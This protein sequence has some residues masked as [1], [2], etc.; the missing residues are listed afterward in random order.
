MEAIKFSE[1][2]TGDRMPL[3]D[4]DGVP[5]I[6]NQ[7]NRLL[8]WGRLKK[9]LAAQ[10]HTD[11]VKPDDTKVPTGA[12]V[13]KRIKATEDDLQTKLEP[14]ETKLDEHDTA[15][16]NAR[17]I[18]NEA[19]TAADSAYGMATTAAT[20]AEDAVSA[21]ATAQN[22]ADN[23]ALAASQAQTAANSAKAD[24]ERFE[25]ELDGKISAIS[26]AQ[27]QLRT[28]LDAETTARENALAEVSSSVTAVSSR[29]AN[30]ETKIENGEIG[31][32]GNNTEV[33]LTP[34]TDRLTALEAKDTTHDNEI[35]A[36]QTKT[37]MN[38]NKAETLEGTVAD[39][40]EQMTDI[41]QRFTITKTTTAIDEDGVETTTS[42]TMPLNQYV[43]EYEDRIVALETEMAAWTGDI[44]LLIAQLA[45]TL[46]GLNS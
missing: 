4:E 43:Q 29:I 23:A 30:I 15:I 20:T 3:A 2:P 1:L 17:T 18:A 35:S 36:L 25:S 38:A 19:K 33:D 41:N 6:A 45:D 13:E 11:E 9:Q 7:E 16:E 22:K 24:A 39:L 21:A 32:G 8:T 28:D 27:G 10:T 44:K 12:A 37:T 34:V 14:L 42:V 31:G 40:A 46:Q 26:T 5:I